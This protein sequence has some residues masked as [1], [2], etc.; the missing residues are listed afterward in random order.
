MIQIDVG[1]LTY[2]KCWYNNYSDVPEGTS[3]KKDV[4]ITT[5]KY[6]TTGTVIKVGAIDEHKFLRYELDIPGATSIK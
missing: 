6:G 2:G 4:N 5:T 3:E 1:G